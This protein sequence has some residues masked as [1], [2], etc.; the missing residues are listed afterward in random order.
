MSGLPPAVC[1][2]LIGSSLLMCVLTLDV[3]RKIYIYWIKVFKFRGYQSLLMRSFVLSVAEER[4][5][6][7]R[8][9]NFRFFFT[10]S[11]N[12]SDRLL[13]LETDGRWGGE[14]GAKGH[15][16]KVE[17]RSCVALKGYEQTISLLSLWNFIV[18]DFRDTQ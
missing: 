16:D 13:Q 15:G 18:I 7:L 17:Q 11:T 5:K 9:N 14:R 10:I 2:T 1:L 4:G 3:C 12:V 8:G 6:V